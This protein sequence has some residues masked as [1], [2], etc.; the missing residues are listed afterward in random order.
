MSDV[1]FFNLLFHLTYDSLR[2]IYLLRV[3]VD[4]CDC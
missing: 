1:V 3:T 2:F 4:P